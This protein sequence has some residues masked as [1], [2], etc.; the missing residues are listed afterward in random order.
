MYNK[1]IE[2]TKFA[3]NEEDF[4]K[5][6]SPDTIIQPKVEEKEKSI[7]QQVVEEDEKIDEEIEMES[8]CK[9]EGCKPLI[10]EKEDSQGELQQ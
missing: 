5:L 6:V 9:T 7:I 2:R 10:V 4:D 8:P 3:S 1:D